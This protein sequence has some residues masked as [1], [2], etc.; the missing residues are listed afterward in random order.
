MSIGS[1]KPEPVRFN[2]K[3][4]G[5]R[6]IAV[7]DPDDGRIVYQGDASG[8]TTEIY[9]LIPGKKYLYHVDGDFSWDS[10]FTPEGTLRMIRVDGVR[11]VRDLGGWK[12]DDRSIKYGKIYRGAELNSIS[13][14]GRAVLDDL[15]VSVDIDLRGGNTNTLN[16]EDYYSYSVRYFEIS[17][18]SGG[19]YAEAIRKIVRL[20]SEDKVV[21]FH[22]MVGADRTGTLAFLIEA[23][24]G[25]SESDLS[26]DFELTSFYQTRTRNGSSQ[27]ALKRLKSA[28]NSYSGNNIQEKVLSWADQFGLEPDV[29][30][31]LQ[32]LLLE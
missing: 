5:T 29:I 11:N 4:S 22:C 25:V 27:F 23:L 10:S 13:S 24:L 12:A 9:N 18:E 30:E 14:N 20:L 3:Y 19:L 8:Q 7:S 15:N 32:Q 2:W 31:Q 1:D 21:Y 6:T 17:G 16:L 26:K 28:L